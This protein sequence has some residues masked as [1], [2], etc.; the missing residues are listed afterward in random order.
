MTYAEDVAR[1]ALQAL[2]DYPPHEPG[3]GGSEQATR[4]DR[5][6]FIEQ[7]ARKWWVTVRPD[8]LRAHA[9]DIQDA[10]ERLLDE[11]RNEAD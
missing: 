11:R 2:D 8:T 4:D 1:I 5:N 9:G 7:E 6:A 3:D 10:V